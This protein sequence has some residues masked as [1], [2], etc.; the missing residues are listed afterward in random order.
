MRLAVAV[1]AVAVRPLWRYLAFWFV[2]SQQF[3]G[4]PAAC[5]SF[6]AVVVALVAAVVVR[7]VGLCL[8]ACGQW[9]SGRVVCLVVDEWLQGCAF[10]RV[11]FCHLR[12]RYVFGACVRCR[13]SLLGVSWTGRWCRGVGRLVVDLCFQSCV[14]SNLHLYLVEGRL[15]VDEL[16]LSVR[17]AK[18]VAVSEC[19]HV[20]QLFMRFCLVE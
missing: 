9:G 6:R 1:G 12:V 8:A 15:L 11:S 17:Y 5:V 19:S 20:L 10:L 2:V 3:L 18:C 13:S 4:G 16:C 7:F 14:D